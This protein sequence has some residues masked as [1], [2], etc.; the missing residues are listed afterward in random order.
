MSSLYNESSFP[1]SM[2]ASDIKD[3]EASNE[4]DILCRIDDDELADIEFACR[5]LRF[6][7]CS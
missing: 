2:T 3:F 7:I 5:T 4:Y 6:K 1:S